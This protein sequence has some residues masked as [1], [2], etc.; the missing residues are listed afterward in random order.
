MIW[1]PSGF[2]PDLPTHIEGLTTKE[3]AVMQKVGK[4]QEEMEGMAKMV[5]GMFARQKA[6]QTVRRG[7]FGLE[8]EDTPQGARIRAVT[9]EGPAAQAG[10]AAGDLIVKIVP[11]KSDGEAVRTSAD[12]LRLTAHVTPGESALFVFKRGTERLKRSVSAG[13]EGF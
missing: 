4:N 6:L 10:L 13:K 8:L 5:S 1:T 12:L 7:F 11:P 3:R 9:P 2:M